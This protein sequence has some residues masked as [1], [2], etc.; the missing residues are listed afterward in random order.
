MSALLLA[1][2]RGAGETL[3]PS[4]TAVEGAALTAPCP[5]FLPTRSSTA[6][7]LECRGEMEYAF[8]SS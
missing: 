2:V 1:L 7:Q 5:R 3:S 4:D 6:T 8:C